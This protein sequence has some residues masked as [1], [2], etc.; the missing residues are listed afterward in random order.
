MT[1]LSNEPASYFGHPDTHQVAGQI[2][3]LGETV[4]GLAG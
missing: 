3:A 1:S 2:M 4:Q